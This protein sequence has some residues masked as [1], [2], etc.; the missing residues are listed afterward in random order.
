MSPAEH[1]RSYSI[2]EAA[3]ILCISVPTLRMYE[4]E[5][6]VIPSRRVSGHR[7]YTETDLERVR[8]YRQTMA[9]D[10]VTIAHLKRLLSLIP[11]WEINQCPESSRASC[12][13]YPSRQA[14]CWEVTE[15]SWQAMCSQCQECEVYKKSQ[16]AGELVRLIAE[17]TASGEGEANRG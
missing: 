1:P 7:A 6:L 17:Y 2:S 14:P 4:R 10:K 8:C 9:R 11:C 5:G 15:K 16:D 3:D 12:K 13:A